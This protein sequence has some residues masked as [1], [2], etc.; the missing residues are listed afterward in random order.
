MEIKTQV[1]LNEPC[2]QTGIWVESR[3]QQAR[4]DPRL[5]R[6]ADVGDSTIVKRGHGGEQRRTRV[7]TGERH[8]ERSRTRPHPRDDTWGRGLTRRALCQQSLDAE[9][10]GFL[11]GDGTVRSSAVGLSSAHVRSALKIRFTEIN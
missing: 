11:H 6:G 5:V 7:H 10:L 9:V 1:W 3:Q 4:A 8:R 2:T